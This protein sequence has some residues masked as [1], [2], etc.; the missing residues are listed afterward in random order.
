TAA[1]PEAHLTSPGVA[2]GTIAYMSPEQVR[3]D[4]LDFRTDLFSFGLVLYEM[5]TGRQAFSG[6]TSGVIFHAILSQTPTP[7]LWLNAEL[8][9]KVEE[10]INKALEKD[11][12]MRYQSA[13]ELRT[14]LKRLKRDTDSA[15]S[16]GVS[17]VVGS[18]ATAP[19]AVPREQDLSSDSQMVAELVKRHK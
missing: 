18:V 1:T 13:S 10:I 16:T 15:P 5:A 2:M 8:P 7:V 9:P 6:K 12:G 11:R 17:A 14:D 4:E 3:G 19:S